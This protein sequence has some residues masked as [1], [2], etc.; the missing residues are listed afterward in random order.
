MTD[1][2]RQQAD[3]SWAPA[4]PLPWDD[5]VD[6]EVYGRGRERRAVAYW[7]D[8]EL[9]RVG[10]GAFFGLRLRLA[11]RRLTRLLKAQKR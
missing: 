6:W 3:G 4:E 2:Q 8:Q 10:T 11:H 7:R 1:I 5:R 9:G